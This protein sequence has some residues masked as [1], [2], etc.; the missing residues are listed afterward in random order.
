MLQALHE[1]WMTVAQNAAELAC[2]QIE[3][4]VP[5]GVDHVAAFAANDHTIHEGLE[6][7]EILAVMLP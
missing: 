4:A 5:I 1:S 3:N 6:Q 7:K 2:C